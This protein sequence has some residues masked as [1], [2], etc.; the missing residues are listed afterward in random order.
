MDN[1]SETSTALKLQFAN[2]LEK[3]RR[4]DHLSW[5]GDRNIRLIPE[6]QSPVLS[7]LTRLQPSVIPSVVFQLLGRCANNHS[8]YL[9]IFWCGTAGS[10][11]L[12]NLMT[13][14]SG[15]NKIISCLDQL[16]E[17]GSRLEGD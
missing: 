10:L 9:N 15:G 8:S 11:L 7:Y 2:N 13:C 16:E 12:S 3:P 14:P 4:A 1:Y 5:K 17:E 6:W